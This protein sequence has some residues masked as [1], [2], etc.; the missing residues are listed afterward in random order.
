VPRDAVEEDSRF[1]GDEDS[2]HLVIPERWK[3]PHK[4]DSPQATPV[5][6]VESL[7]EIEHET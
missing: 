4:H 6:G 3:S 2:L 7:H 5:D 1:R